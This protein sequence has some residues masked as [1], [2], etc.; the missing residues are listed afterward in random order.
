MSDTKQLFEIL[1]KQIKLDSLL[2]SSDAFIDGKLNKLE[3]HKNSKRWTFFFEFKR[4]LPFN[5]FMTFVKALKASFDGIAQVNFE[6]KT[7]DSELSESEIKD[8]WNYVLNDCNVE[9]PMVLDKIS[10]TPPH[11]EN[12][13]V[14]LDVSNSFMADFVDG[15]VI[16]GLQSEYSSLG[17][18][19]FRIRTNVDKAKYQEKT[20]AMKAANAEK[21][22]QF[23]AK[24]KEV[25]AKKAA[26]PAGNVS[27]VGRKIP[28]DQEVTQ[29]V[30]IIEED[31]NK[32]V[33]GYVFDIDVRKLKSGRSLL[34]MKVTDYTSSFSI[35]KFSNGEDDEN[36]FASLDQ[37]AWIRVR[38]NVQEDN[39]SREL[40]IMANDINIIKHEMR[41]DTAEDE[42]KRIELHAHTNMSQMDAIPSA[43]DLIKRASDWG[44]TG[45]A[46]TDHRAL[47]AFPEAYNAGKKF[48][49]K[50]AYGVEVDL[51]DEGNPIAYNLRDQP[52]NGSEYV[53][54]DTET[55]GLSAVYDSIIEIGATK[56]KDGEVIERFDKFINPGHPLSEVTTN[57]TSITD[58]M[59]KDAPDETV[60]IGEFMDFIGDDILVGH[61]VTFDM[62]F[63]NAA[64]T[65]MGR[66]RLAMPVIDT[67]EM[68]RT[69]H[70]E[71][72]NHKLDSLTKRY[73]I[74]LEH[75]HRADS[76]AETTG[77]LMY[78]LFDELEDKFGTRNV[79]QLNDHVGGEEAYKQA[80]P[81]HAVLLAKTQA[82]LK[83]MFKIVSYSM[84]RY[85]YRTARVPR[86]LLNKYREGIIVGSACENGEVFT[87]MM[88]KGYDDTRELAQYYDYL[89][90]MPQTLYQHLI[91]IK[92]IKDEDALQ[93]IIK[94]IVKLG[95]ELNKPVVATGDVHYLDPHDK[96]YRDIVIKAVKS[97]AL[98]RRPELPDVQFRT[99][100]EMFDEFDFMDQQTE[101]E[102]IVDNPKKIM[103]SIDEI[104][105][106][107]DKLYTPKMEGAED[108]IRSLTMNKAH[109]LYGDPL[110]ELVQKRMDRELKSIIGNGFSVIY[111]IA[112]RLVYKS[113]KDGYLVGSRGSVGSSFVATM[114]GIT[115]VN[116]L[117]PH[118]RCPNCKYSEFFTKGEVG[119]GYDLPDKD[120]PKCGTNMKKDG[121]DIPFETFLGFKGDKVPDIDLNFSGDYQPVAHNY[122]KVLFG[123]DHVFRAG[124]IGTIAD[125]T[126]FGYVKNYEE[127]TGQ[128]FRNAEEERLAMGSTGVK[129]T[130]GQHPAG[131]IVVPDY[132]D[133]FDFTPIQYPADDQTALWKTTH[134]DFHSIHDNIL[135][136]D[137]LG[138]DDPT[139]IRMLQDLSGIDPKTLPVKDPGVMELFRGTDSLDVTPEQIFS[140]TGTLGVPEFGTRFVRGMLEK[141]HPTTFAELLQISGLSHGTDVW[142]GNAEEL[143]DKGVV[144]LKEVIGCRDNIMMDLI[145]Y[146]MDSQMA[147]QIM[148]HV[149]KGRGIPDDWK[150]A[151][152]DADVPDWYID[153]CLKIK[154]M[155]PRAH[156][157]A[158]II[159]ALRIAYFKVHHPL[160]YYC[161]Y[162]SV[163]ADDFDLV[164]MT[165]GKD[166]VKA[167]MKAINDKGMDAS[168]KEKNLLT[169]LEL[170]N[171]CLE[172]GFKI[173][174]VDLDKSDA[175][176]FKIIDDKTLLAPFNA[177]PG[178]G[179]NVAKQ[180]VAAREEQP[181]LS[182]QDLGTRGKVSKTVIEYM[183]E[184]HVLDGMPDE[185]Q[186]SLF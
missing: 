108:E 13:Q 124:T 11:V 37:G 84:T 110:P 4:V 127:L 56:M 28:D 93:E 15:K 140:K 42:N 145:H 138:H 125:R 106:V 115:E 74:V 104:S 6:I 8:Y 160:Y 34:I 129:R 119:S 10:Q 134:F 63:M 43:T 29:M 57:L 172:R 25:S 154:Y 165:T 136:L 54:F 23:Q 181:F 178:L 109:E 98:A 71:Y 121:Q 66:P 33:E 18:P 186:L 21:T 58:D 144:T 103:D 141:T 47:Q 5:D 166:A 65:R 118:Y 167:S 173:K 78:K 180:I 53:I 113:N 46:I 170:A 143:I 59:V 162:F 75:H 72:R 184:N 80:R 88:Q 168:T 182:K 175:F 20:E 24:A 64:L 77:Y 81:S 171:E 96:V 69:L 38:G 174:M 89:E 73:H 48:G 85:F 155:F 12:G 101:Q 102:I 95:K 117:P 150:Q 26:K 114:T 131:I 99:T 62:G 82:G 128:N 68:S 36:F 146:G 55:T 39:F 32:V 164:A 97:N 45:I 161:A 111:L 122:T 133:I 17:F 61:N 139:M 7:T 9:S 185:N 16:D 148:E 83:N 120:C 123:E 76:D 30:D 41:K 1:V 158:Y 112:Q 40:V 159:M 19:D 142:L 132:M 107:K 137:I 49:V 153:S 22:K 149:R 179:D 152:K 105:P 94:N 90:V 92:I 126:A 177:I 2:T 14:F 116:P 44:Q 31:R 147:F 176:D 52:L 35:K 151:M 87:S 130:T 163:R 67:L 156:A 135:K 51:V 86:R 183:T 60:I 50:I 100:N 70:S 79:N 169:V 157:T 3:V 27:K 91:D